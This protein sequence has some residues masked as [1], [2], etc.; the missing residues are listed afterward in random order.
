MATRATGCMK[1]VATNTCYLFTDYCSR[2][3]VH[4]HNRKR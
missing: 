4:T 2:T 1:L 3:E